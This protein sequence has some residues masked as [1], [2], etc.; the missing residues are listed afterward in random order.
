MENVPVAGAKIP[1]FVR[2]IQQNFAEICSKIQR[3]YTLRTADGRF[4]TVALIE[5]LSFMF[6]L[7]IAM[8]LKYGADLPAFVKY[9]GWTHGLLFILYFFMLIDVY[10]S[11][12]WPIRQVLLA[13][14]ASVLPFGYFIFEK[15]WR[16]KQPAS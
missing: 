5:S 9:G 8:P 15:Y 7:F 6:L 12:R 10:I 2:E 16:S 1:N 14:L 3:M 4:R 11:D 13:A